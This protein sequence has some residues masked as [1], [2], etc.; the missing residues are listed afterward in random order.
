MRNFFI[1]AITALT[2]T[3]QFACQKSGGIKTKNGNTVIIHTNNSGPKITHGQSVLINVNTW[4]NDSLVQ[5][6]VRDNGGPR[7]FTIPDT[8]VMKNR[9]PAVFDALLYM[10]NGDSATVLQPV[11]SIMARGIPKEF[12]EI[13]N[14]RFEVRVVDVLT[15]EKITARE[16]EK[17]QKAEAEKAKGMEVGSLLKT[18]LDDYKA[19][20]LGDKLKKTASGLEYVILEQGDGPAVKDGASIPTHYYGV[21]KTT[22]VMFDNSFDRGQPIPFTVGDLVE[23]FNEGMKLLNRGGKCILFIPYQLAYGEQGSGPIPPKSDLVF[24]LGLEK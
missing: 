17:Q 7:E 4:L 12:G 6:T 3:F 14:I 1:L 21:L 8:S 18:T 22:G 24:Y 19:N 13:K 16:A 11:D 5:S 15:P 2:M 10:T 23:G 9:V 20:K